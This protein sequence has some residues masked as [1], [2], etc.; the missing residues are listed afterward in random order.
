MK[1]K[2]IKH[3]LDKLFNI[4]FRAEAFNIL[5][6]PIRRAMGLCETNTT[7]CQLFE[8]SSRS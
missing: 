4:Q 8:I 5:N 1:D 6:Y 2:Y 7:S 3:G